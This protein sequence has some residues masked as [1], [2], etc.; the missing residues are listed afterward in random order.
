MLGN[1]LG[2]FLTYKYKDYPD[3]RKADLMSRY[4][5]MLFWLALLWIILEICSIIYNVGIGSTIMY[6]VYKQSWGLRIG[7]IVMGIGYLVIKKAASVAEKN[8]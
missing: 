6:M 8:R 3:C 7:I 2:V 5:T 1:I 4:G